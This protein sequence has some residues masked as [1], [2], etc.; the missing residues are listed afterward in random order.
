MGL[1]RLLLAVAVLLQHVSGCKYAMTGGTTS[2]Q[3]FYVVSGFFIAMILDLKYSRRDQLWLFYS[4]RA[5]RI[6]ATYWLFAAIAVLLQIA[7]H[8]AAHRSVFDLWSSNST[9]LGSGGTW[10]LVLT[11]IFLFGQD[12]ALFTTL[13]THGLHWSVNFWQSSPIVP[14]FMLIPPAWSLSLELTFYLVAPWILRKRTAWI[15]ALMVLSLL[16]RYGLWVNGLRR[17]PWSYRFFPSELC[18]FLGGA[19]AYRLVYRNPRFENLSRPW[20][21]FAVGLVP[22]VVLYP[23]YDRSYN[24]FFSGTK[25]LY[26]IYVLLAV[27]LIFRLTSSWSADRLLGELSYPFYLCHFGIVQGLNHASQRLGVP[28]RAAIAIVLSCGVAYLSV[29]VLDHPLDRFRQSRI[30]R[31]QR[32]GARTSAREQLSTEPQSIEGPPI[33]G[34]LAGKD[35]KMAC[36]TESA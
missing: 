24:L 27:P 7:G 36:G 2:V 12:L 32:S 29:V 22:A 21:F 10:F 19:L 15:V 4:N 33:S 31:S 11:N 17:D 18:L 28:V 8:M 35:G 34:D 23:L 5:L 9:R 16:I 20:K 6:Y 3:T 1:F 14:E 25:L 30:T 26:L 13:G